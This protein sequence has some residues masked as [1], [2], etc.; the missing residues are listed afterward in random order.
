MIMELDDLK[1]RWKEKTNQKPT[2]KSIMEMIQH[3]SYGP[4]AAL[5][6]SYR[7]Q[8]VVMLLMPFI[9]LFTNLQDITKPLSSVMYWSYVVFCLGMIAMSLNNYII[10]HRMQRM[11]GL[12]KENLEQQITLL[13]TRM[14]WTIIGLRLALLFFIVLAEVLPYFQ[15]FR[16][17]DKWHSLSVF[18][19]FGLYAALLILQF[20]ISPLVLQRK[21]G[22]HLASLKELANEL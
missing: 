9:L 22:R 21:F 20:F 17:L 18:I 12:L 6:R 3:K 4:V 15:H 5:K 7:K 11:D 8:I 1:Q 10:A 2:N 13:Q 14:K 16:M 19:R